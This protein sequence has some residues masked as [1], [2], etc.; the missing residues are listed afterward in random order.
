MTTLR[1]DPNPRA[2]INPW[3]ADGPLAGCP[4]TVVSCF[5]RNLVDYAVERFGGEQ[6]HT[7][8]FA[9]MPLPLWRI[10]SGGAELGLTMTFQGAP[11]AVGQYESLF[12]LGVERILVF[13]TCGVLRR[14]IEDCAILIPDRAV[15]DEGTSR[16]YAPESDEIDANVRTLPMLRNFFSEKGLS[17]TVG[18][19]WTIDAFFRETP[20]RVAERRAQGCIAVEMEC[21]A[22]A[23][24]A[25]FRKKRVA[26][27]LYAAD[28][29]DAEVWDERSLANHAGMD[30]KRRLMD[31]AVELAARWEANPDG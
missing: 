10:R 6:I 28:N 14:D 29:L 16:H 31:W 11:N 23:A 20:D 8:E 12:T 13:G 15:R 1:F 30:A 5:A 19:V 4:R 24:L 17:A 3:D 21:A 7:V 27:F 18:K 26:Q 25:Q 2:V 9:N 22:L